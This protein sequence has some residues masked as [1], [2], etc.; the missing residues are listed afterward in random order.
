MNILS[1]FFI[2]FLWKSKTLNFY[3]LGLIDNSFSIFEVMMF[4]QQLLAWL[5]NF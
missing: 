5:Y 2:G 3:V 1:S 4:D